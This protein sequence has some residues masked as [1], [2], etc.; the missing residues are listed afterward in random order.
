MTNS[1]DGHEPVELRYRDVLVARSSGE[2][3]F[4]NAVSLSLS[5]QSTCAP[6]GI[7]TAS[8]LAGLQAL[9]EE[10]RRR[11]IRYDRLLAHHPGRSWWHFFVGGV[12]LRFFRS[13]VRRFGAS[14]LFFCEDTVLLRTDHEEVLPRW[15]GFDPQTVAETLS[16]NGPLHFEL[17]PNGF[18]QGIMM[19]QFDAGTFSDHERAELR[20]RIE[21]RRGQEAARQERSR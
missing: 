19:V 9:E 13:M 10:I 5:F 14:G 12:T 20:R 15:Q 21:L 3:S 16:G 18:F 4:L 6:R 8:D 1:G 11:G 7:L 2:P 17:R